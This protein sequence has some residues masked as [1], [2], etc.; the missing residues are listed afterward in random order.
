MFQID[1]INVNFKVYVSKRDRSFKMLQNI[2]S[3]LIQISTTMGFFPNISIKFAFGAILFQT[4]VLLLVL[5]LI[6][7]KVAFKKI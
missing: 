7:A 2:N 6:F 4:F 3:L 5:S 1:T